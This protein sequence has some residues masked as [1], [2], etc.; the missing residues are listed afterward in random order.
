MITRRYEVE[1]FGTKF[2]IISNVQEKLVSAF[3]PKQVVG[4]YTKDSEQYV[5]S[6][7]H[8]DSRGGIGIHDMVEALH[9]NRCWWS[10]LNLD[11]Q[12]HLLL[13]PKAVDCGNDTAAAIANII[14]YGGTLYVAFGVDV[15]TW[16][17]AT[18]SWNDEAHALAAVPT[19]AVV[20]NNKLYYASSIDFERFN[21]GWTTGLALSGGAKPALFFVVW[22]NKLLRLTS[23][24]QLS[25]SVD[26]GVTWTNNA[27]STLPAGSFTSLFLTRNGVDEIVP[28]LGTKY[29]VYE[30]DFT[31]AVW[32][33]AGLQ[34]PKQDYACQGARMW[35]DTA[36][37]I[38]VGT[39]VYQ[40]ANTS[41]GMTITP[42]G[43]DRDYGLPTEYRGNIIQV[44]PE[45]NGLYVLLAVAVEAPRDLYAASF[46]YDSV[47][48]DD[49]GYS[50]IFKWNGLGW[51]VIRSS[52]D[53]LATWGDINNADS[54]YRFWF[55]MGKTVY[56]IP[57][58]RDILNP[59][60]LPDYEFADSGEHIWGWFDADNAVVDKL[61]VSI[62]AY[63]ETGQGYAQLYYGTDYSDGWT[64]LTNTDFPDGKIDTDGEVRFTLNESF[65]AIRFKAYLSKGNTS[66][67]VRWVRLE[68][69][70]IPQPKY[71]YQVTID[72][73]RDYAHKRAGT[74]LEA[75]KTAVGSK[76]LGD[77]TYRTVNGVNTTE[78]VRIMGMTGATIAG[79]I[80]EGIYQVQLLAP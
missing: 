13:P 39:G 16:V 50:A 34:F 41:S 78:Q 74:L 80:K 66:P 1:L 72:C 2:P 26:E 69:I 52:E 10:T 43:L 29:G 40:Y 23:A 48:Y 54:K 64:L 56:Y 7:V 49:E 32:L 77:F 5:S 68:Y 21:G 71:S 46:T 6:L 51:S 20:Y 79:K 11:L 17:D 63:V 42:M 22:D 73:T 53:S 61:A 14:E 8:S 35:R 12:G 67:D 55:A 59:L 18:T 60:E 15:W 3:A 76:E 65:K 47:I 4:D 30:L 62:G 70:K 27:L 31:S 9:A 33:S 75:L 45:L 57:L 38:P 24:G 36:A 25:Y 58:T 19:D 37:Y 28:H 44:I